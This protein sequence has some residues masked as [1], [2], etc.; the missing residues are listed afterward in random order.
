[1]KN[2]RRTYCSTT[3]NLSC[4]GCGLIS[5]KLELKRRKCDLSRKYGDS[6]RTIFFGGQKH[7]DSTG[8]ECGFMQHRCNIGYFSWTTTSSFFPHECLDETNIDANS[9]VANCISRYRNVYRCSIS[10]HHQ[11]LDLLRLCLLGN[12]GLWKRILKHLTTYIKSH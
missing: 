11:Q 1:M 10:L 2:N 5:H 12:L 8:D 6:V 4:T 7:W 3:L 9:T